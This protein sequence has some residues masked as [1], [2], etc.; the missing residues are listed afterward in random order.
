M[1]RRFSTSRA[2]KA[3][4]V[5][6]WAALNSAYL[7]GTTVSNIIVHATWTAA[8]IGAITGTA[9]AGAS[10][11]LQR[12]RSAELQASL[13]AKFEIVMGKLSSI[14]EQLGKTSQVQGKGT[15]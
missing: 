9:V 10:D 5:D 2:A 15:K 13:D 1:F 6:D 7:S 4:S 11:W 8:V 3:L 14:E 12:Y